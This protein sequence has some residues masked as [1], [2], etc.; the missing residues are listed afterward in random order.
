MSVKLGKHYNPLKALPSGCSA[1]RVYRIYYVKG[2][3]KVKRSWC[4]KEVK[5]VRGL[6]GKDNESSQRGGG[7]V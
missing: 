5:S 2:P 7:I 1:K 4:K 3:G 6:Y